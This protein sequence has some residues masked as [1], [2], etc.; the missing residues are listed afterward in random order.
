MTAEE[1]LALYDESGHPCGAAPRSRVRAENLRHAATGVVVRNDAGQLYVHRRTDTKDVYPGRYD[2][3]SGGCVLAGEAPVAAAH[4]ELAEELGIEGVELRPLGSRPYGDEVTRYFAYVFETRWNG[5]VRLQPEEIVWGGWL[6]PA[7]LLAHVDG[8]L[9]RWP[10]VPDTMG[11]LGGWLRAAADSSAIP[12][13]S[14]GG[15][16]QTNQSGGGSGLPR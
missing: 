3:A 10:M 7:E 9:V 1:I 4:R 2:F 13:A 8:P 14:R 11:T 12:R 6:S 5:P 16:P 15:R